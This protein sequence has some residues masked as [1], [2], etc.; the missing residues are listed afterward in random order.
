MGR[1]N[2]IYRA[3][4][5][6]AFFAAFAPAIAQ[7][8]FTS[9]P[10]GGV[11][12]PPRPGAY[13]GPPTPND[14]APA[15]ILPPPADDDAPSCRSATT[16]A[17]IKALMQQDATVSQ[18]IS[19]MEAVKTAESTK[20]AQA[21]TQPA[22]DAQQKTVAELANAVAADDTKL[23]ALNATRDHLVENIS[24]LQHLKAC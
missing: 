20:L 7:A 23:N 12:P 18:Q 2:I 9:A 14:E 8:Q 3:F 19:A 22:N 11:P 21:R 17:Q 1:E 13:S 24:E 6:V 5:A 16:E 15:V 10:N 4:S